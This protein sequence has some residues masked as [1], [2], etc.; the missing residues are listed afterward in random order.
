MKDVTIIIP[1]YNPDKEIIKKV[2]D[3]IKNQEY[4]GKI[5]VLKLQKGGF[6]AT[7]NYGLKKA[8]TEIVISLHQDCVPSSKTGLKN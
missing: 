3:A 6:G 1:I 2:D 5:T 8:K 4:K 7:F